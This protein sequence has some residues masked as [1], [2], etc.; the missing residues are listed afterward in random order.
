MTD[1]IRRIARTVAE[2]T[3]RIELISHAAALDAE[4]EED[5]DGLSLLS[6]PYYPG[7]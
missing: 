4:A 7:G 1:S 3:D 2:R 6:Q 5:A